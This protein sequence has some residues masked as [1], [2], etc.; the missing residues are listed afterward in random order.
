MKRGR[1]ALLGGRYLRFQFQSACPVLAFEGS[2]NALTVLGSSGPIVL[3][4][5]L[6]PKVKCDFLKSHSPT[7]M[8][9]WSFKSIS[10]SAGPKTHIF[11]GPYLVL[12]I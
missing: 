8:I 7:R 3:H 10:Q 11:L 4:R 5:N 6:F 9:S 1:D 12:D 2:Q